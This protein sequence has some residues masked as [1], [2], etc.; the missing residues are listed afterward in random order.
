MAL[1]LSLYFGEY[2]STVYVLI[3]LPIVFFLLYKLLKKIGIVGSSPKNNEERITRNKEL[4]ETKERTRQEEKA[5]LTNVAKNVK[6]IIKGDTTKINDLNQDLDSSIKRTEQSE[7]ITKEIIEINKQTVKEEGKETEESKRAIQEQKSLIVK[8][9][10]QNP[11]II[12]LAEERIQQEEERQILFSELAML[13]QAHNKILEDTIKLEEQN[14][15]QM[16]EMLKFTQQAFL[17]VA[18]N[19]KQPGQESL[20][21]LSSST[22]RIIQ[23]EK[24]IIDVDFKEVKVLKEIQKRQVQLAAKNEE[25][26]QLE[27]KE[28]RLLAATAGPSN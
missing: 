13:R 9:Q 5:R 10:E 23:N 7:T 2:L 14:R 3:G 26:K 8:S 18:N 1:D 11:E 12:K 4:R 25:V 22:E 24:D 27:G 20:K 21:R 17:I 16:T 6:E 15:I 28:I 19:Q